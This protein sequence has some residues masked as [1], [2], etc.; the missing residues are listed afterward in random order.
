MKYLKVV[1]I[2]SESM[3][4]WFCYIG[5]YDLFDWCKARKLTKRW[6]MKVLEL[7]LISFYTFKN[8]FD[9]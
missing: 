7:N 9:S 2:E 8:I 3:G 5:I 1:C 4:T 6:F